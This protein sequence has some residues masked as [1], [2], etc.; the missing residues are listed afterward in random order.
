MTDLKKPENILELIRFQ[1]KLYKKY[2]RYLNQL[3]KEKYKNAALLTYWLN[4]YLNY[5]KAE[6]TFNPR[7]SINYKRG[8]IVY[9]NFGYRIG[10]ELG[11]CH[12]AIVLDV[13][14]SIKNSQVTVIPMKSKR[15]HETHYSRI[16]HVDLY[17]EIQLL[18][19]EKS[20]GIIDNETKLV[21][22]LVAQY[23]LEGIKND[24]K[25]AKQVA[26]SKRK[27]DHAQQI[28]LFAEEK[29][30]HQSIADVGQICTVSKIRIVHPTKKWDVLTNVCLSAGTM[31]RIEEKIKYLFLLSDN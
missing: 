10:S 14:S 19:T 31:N 24:A 13:K 18:L 25:I 7:F 29:L 23:G 11:G 27:L 20:V 21:A 30:N 4:N 22:Q 12:Y 2:I 17:E 8:Q 5:L 16:Y 26:E 28:R 3:I 9:V 1:K 6:H 15:F